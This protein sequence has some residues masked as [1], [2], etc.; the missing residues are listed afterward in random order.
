MIS[1]KIATMR[2]Y[3]SLLSWSNVRKNASLHNKLLINMVIIFVFL[4]GFP[5][6]QSKSAAWAQAGFQTIKNQSGSPS[7]DTS[8]DLNA[9]RYSQIFS[10]ETSKNMLAAWFLKLELPEEANTDE[11]SGDS[12]ILISP[13]NKVML[14]DGG[15]PPC[16][17]KVCAYLHALDI[18]RIDAMIVS[19]PHI[20]HIGGLAQVLEEFPVDIIYMSKLEYPTTPFMNFVQLKNKGICIAYLQEGSEF[21]LAIMCMQRFI[22]QSKLS[23]TLADTPQ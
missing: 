15:A 7:T 5:E 17:S 10:R 22:I 3:I 4:C 13:D 11:K 18:Q 16:G 8:E 1:W 6:V 19:H 23:P 14:I 9:G 2:R 21:V 20:D 12:T